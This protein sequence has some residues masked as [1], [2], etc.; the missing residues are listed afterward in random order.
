M[1]SAD[2]TKACDEYMQFILSDEYH[3]DKLGNYEH[4]IFEAAME[5]AHGPK[6]WDVINRV[7]V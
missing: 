3:E 1:K 2:V 4:A 7:I 6:V 5:A